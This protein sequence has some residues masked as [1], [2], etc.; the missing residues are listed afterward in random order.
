MDQSILLQIY[1]GEYAPYRRKDQNSSGYD[2]FMALQ[3]EIL[4]ALPEE[5]R[6]LMD[7]VQDEINTLLMDEGESAFIEG[8]TF[9]VR[10]MMEVGGSG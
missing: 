1:R 10:L 5:K 7:S 6:P 9:G 3:E 2:K 8:V 4:A